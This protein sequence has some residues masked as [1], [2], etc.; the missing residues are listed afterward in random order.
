MPRE[1]V[2]TRFVR[3]VREP[4][5]VE[6]GRDSLLAVHR[7]EA[8]QPRRIAQIVGGGELIVEADRVGQIADAALDRERLA[9]RIEPEHAHLAAGY[10]G[11]SEQHQDG[12]R[13]P[14][15]I[16][17]EQPEYFP[18]LD[19]ERDVIDRGRAAIGLGEAVGLDDDVPA[20]RRPNLATAPTMTRSATPMMPTPAMPHMVEVVTV[21]RKV[22]EAD[23]PRA[24]AR[25]VVT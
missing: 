12:G 9:R 6:R 22:A 20:H 8:D 23:S 16:G 15:A 19:A 7:L 14:R 1:K 18:A 11:Q 10:F 5:L 13:L 25:T 21:T 2:P 4:D 24:E 17:P 3:E